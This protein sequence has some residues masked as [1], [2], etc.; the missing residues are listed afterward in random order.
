MPSKIELFFL[1]KILLIM[2]KTCYLY[3][4]K[5][6]IDASGSM[7]RV[8]QSKI[9]SAAAASLFLAECETQ[10]QVMPQCEENDRIQAW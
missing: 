6:Q 9:G 4:R 2:I 10:Q 3:R 1:K 8:E 5:Y 7:R